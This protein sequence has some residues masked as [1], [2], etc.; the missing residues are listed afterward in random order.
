MAVGWVSTLVQFLAIYG[1]KYTKI[2]V[3]VWECQCFATPFSDTR[4]LVAFRRYSRS[5]REVI[6]NRAE[7]SFF[8]PPN[9]GGMGPKC[10][11][12]F[13]KSWSPITIEHVAKFGDDRPSDLGD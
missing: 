5:S 7:I 11:I 2:S 8:G 13:H 4:C 6:R 1:P 10:L 9:F 3:P 12:E